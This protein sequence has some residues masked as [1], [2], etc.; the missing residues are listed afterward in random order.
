[1]PTTTLL[2][3]G[4]KTAISG[5]SRSLFVLFGLALGCG[6]YVAITVLSDGYGRL[7]SLPFTELRTDLVIQRSIAGGGEK[8]ASG[9]SG[10]RLPFSNQPITATE[11][12][13]LTHLEGVATISPTLLLWHQTKN[14]FSVIAGID[15]RDNQNRIGTTR[16]MDWI[17]KGRPIKHPG[18]AVVK[19]H[20]GRFHKIKIGDR[21]TLGGAE[22]KIVGTASL[23][24][25]ASI[26]AADF[27]IGL[28]DAIKLSGMGPKEANL[29]F[30]RLNKGID[31][32]GIQKKLKKLLP[33][34]IASTADNIGDIM[35]GMSRISSTFAQLFGWVSLLFTGLIGYKLISG[36]I[37]ERVNQI[38][39]LKTIGWQRSDIIRSFTAES[40]LIGLTGGL[41][42]VALG[43]GLAAAFGSME[44][45]LSLP[46]N[47]SPTPGA[48]AAHTQ[49][50]LGEPVSLTLAFLPM[51]IFIALIVA[52][53]VSVLGGY[54]TANQL[55]RIKARE[56]LDR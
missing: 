24:Q 10:I 30:V 46:W 22:F 56:A 44:I 4:W 5:W 13:Q 35:K 51:T 36:S 1:M 16:V 17:K 29:I 20:Y 52:C 50:N 14:G 19:S 21:I 34:A 18:E 26:A 11:I 48:A 39:L 27:Y 32:I 25:G 28:D 43:Y 31:P 55:A 53:V 23:K 15:Q 54:F 12:E 9:T 38:G 45:T 40:A 47:L 41:L 6:L 3:H 37:H 33:G 7:I 2:L 8:S 42:G 49:H